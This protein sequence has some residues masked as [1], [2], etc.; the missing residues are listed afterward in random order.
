[1]ELFGIILSVPVA[2]M[3]SMVYCAL[4]AKVVRRLDRVRRFLLRVSLIVLGS[5]VVELVLLSKL[6]TVRSRAVV[7][8]GFY[9]AHTVFFF[10]GTPALANAL[11][12]GRR[13][14]LVAWWYVA[15]AVRTIFAIFLIL[16][17]YSV[18]EALYGVDGAGGPYS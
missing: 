14:S 6:G 5:F 8:P 4:L 15:G 17:Q 9:V 3:T 11:I 10:L 2:F 7:G 12:L 1:V 13:C 18:S 16:L